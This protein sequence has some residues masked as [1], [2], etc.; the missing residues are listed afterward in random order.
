MKKIFIIILLLI[1]LIIIV[2]SQENK[3]FLRLIN[4]E[5]A[6]LN[7]GITLIR[8]FYNEKNF[9]ASYISNIKWALDKKLIEFSTPIDPNEINQVLTRGDFAYLIC[10]VFNTQGGLVNNKFLTKYQ[11]FKKCVRVGIL[12]NGRGQLDTLTGSELLSS[13]NYLEYYVI[14]NKINIKKDEF[15]FDLN[16]DYLPK[17]RKKFYSELDNERSSLKE[18]RINRKLEREKRKK[19][20]YQKSLERKYKGNKDTEKFIDDKNLSEPE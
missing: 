20:R 16:Y 19:E 10:K 1:P 4:T 12:S 11:A 2:N 9:T 5:I 8:L 17:W 14:N 3:Y 7:D 6:S 13:F 15:E 18:K